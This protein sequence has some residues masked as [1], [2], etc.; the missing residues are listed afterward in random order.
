MT[1]QNPAPQGQPYQQ[2]AYQQ[3]PYQAPPAPNGGY[4][5]PAQRNSLALVALILGIAGFFTGI[6]SIGAIVVGHISLSQIKK[7]GEEGRSMAL[8]GLILGYVAVAL[9]IIA[10]VFVIIFVAAAASTGINYDTY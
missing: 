1:D 4:G 9:F 8:W 6:A 10:I 2:D 7:T 3:N 5:A